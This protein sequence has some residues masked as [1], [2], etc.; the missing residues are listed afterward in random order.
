MTTTTFQD[1]QTPILAS[2]LNDVDSS[3]YQ[4][5]L[6]DGTTNASIDKYTPAG[7][8]AVATTVQTKLRE[9]VSVKDF[10]AKGDGTTDDTTAFNAASTYALA[11]GIGQINI[12]DPVTGAGYKITG[13]IICNSTTRAVKFVGQ[14]KLTT[15]IWSYVTG[16]TPVF[17]YT[18]SSAQIAFG[19]G[20]Y[21]LSILAKNPGAIGSRNSGVAIQILGITGVYVWDVFMQDYTIGLFLSNAVNTWTEQTQIKLWTQ[22]CDYA[23]RMYTASAS[24]PSFRATNGYLYS[25]IQTGQ[26]GIDVMS[27][28]L[29]YNFE[30]NYDWTS[31][32][33]GSPV[34]LNLTS[35]TVQ[36]GVV[37][38]NGEQQDTST[39]V[40]NSSG[41][42][43]WSPQ[44][45]IKTN[46]NLGSSTSV[47]G[48][49]KGLVIEGNQYLS[50][51]RATS[52]AV[53][54]T[55]TLTGVTGGMFGGCLAVIRKSSTSG[56]AVVLIDAGTG[57]TIISDPQGII[58]ITDGGAGSNKFYLAQ[59]G[60]LTN[61]YTT[62]QTIDVII[63][64]AN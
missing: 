62:T 3:T 63:L 16:T 53:G 29:W 13:T 36:Q 20:I 17:S 14:S 22:Y 9:S 50:G 28:T 10:G 11:N 54:G 46:G 49:R 18:A 56:S 25:D 31:H 47:L 4:G 58:S 19:S 45:Y 2:W 59:T 57:V 61:R 15:Q 34:V 8:G 41:G 39:P 38:I 12:P 24:W 23:M 42:A 27:N 51:N 52:L 6:D 5:Q 48:L 33:A 35:C 37:R 26:V 64:G 40:Y 30:F 60:V 55:F 1:F 7:T 43:V 32:G 44:T 21:S